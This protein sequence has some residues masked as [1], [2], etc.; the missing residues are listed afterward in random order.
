[1]KKKGKQKQGMR[2]RRNEK[3]SVYRCSFNGWTTI[4][5]FL[6]AVIFDSH[7]N[8]SGSPSISAKR[9]RDATSLRKPFS[10]LTQKHACAAGP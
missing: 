6:T 9:L 1:M 10:S 4:S 5:V 3:K 8:C 2:R 7:E